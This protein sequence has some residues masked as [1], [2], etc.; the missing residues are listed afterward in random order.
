LADTLGKIVN[1]LANRQVGEL[2]PNTQTKVH[3]R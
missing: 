2:L 3:R 1:G